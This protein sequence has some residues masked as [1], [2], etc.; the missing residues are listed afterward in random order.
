MMSLGLPTSIEFSERKSV[1]E[2][3]EYL[4]FF[5]AFIL[6][7]FWVVWVVGQS[8]APSFPL[9]FVC[10]AHSFISIFNHLTDILL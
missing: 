5:F 2:L 8:S 3:S 10:F 4:F 9:V 6:F 1:S 7:I